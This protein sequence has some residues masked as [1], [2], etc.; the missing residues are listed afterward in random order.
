MSS[1]FDIF[2]ANALRRILA[3]ELVVA[4]RAIDLL[5]PLRTSA[6][7]ESLHAALRRRVL[8]WREDRPL[9]GDLEA[10]DRFAAGPEFMVGKLS[11]KYVLG[12]F[13]SHMW[14]VAGSGDADINLTTITAFATYLPGGG[15]NVGS[16]PIM[17]YDH[18]ADQW[19]IPL[20]LSVGKTVIWNGRPWKLSVEF[21]YFVERNDTFGQEW[22]IGFNAAPVVENVM[23]KWFQ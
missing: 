15:W 1:I 7:L 8:P 19:T 20:N 11:K 9:A 2:E 14:D 10:A 3:I 6:P 16:S 5:R 17:S 12:L 22:F 4:A 23:A 13:P 21:N 18:N